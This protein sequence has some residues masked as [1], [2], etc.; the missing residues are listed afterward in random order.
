M[1]G[2]G[3]ET[4]VSFSSWRN[5]LGQLFEPVTRLLSRKEEEPALS[6]E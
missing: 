6:M 1:N 3:L 4:E 5:F 2:I